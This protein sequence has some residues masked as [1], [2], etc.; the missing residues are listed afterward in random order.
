MTFLLNSKCSLSLNSSR[1]DELMASAI[2]EYLTEHSLPK[3]SKIFVILGHYDDMRQDLL[4]RGEGWVEHEFSS[5]KHE[6][7]GDKNSKFKSNAFHLLYST[8]GKDCFRIPNLSLN[9]HLNHFEGTKGLTTK[10]GLTHN[11]KNL[12][13][14]HSLDID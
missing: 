8:K 2:S 4:D 13:W 7:G 12:V 5:I 14:K 11:M 1:C 3:D 9:Q 10:V 6:K